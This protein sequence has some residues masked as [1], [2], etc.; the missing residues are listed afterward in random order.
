MVDFEEKEEELKIKK[1]V[2]HFPDNPPS[3]TALLLGLPSTPSE[4]NRKMEE[5]EKEKCAQVYP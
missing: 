3:N 5:G 1:D 2:S 4:K